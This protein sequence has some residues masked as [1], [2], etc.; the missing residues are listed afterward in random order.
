MNQA[1]RPSQA[2]VTMKEHHFL[3]MMRQLAR[4]SENRREAGAFLLGP[5]TKSGSDGTR[6]VTAVAYYCDLDEDCLTGGITFHAVGYTRLNQLCRELGSCVLA[7][8]HLHPGRY[9]LQSTTDAAHPM[10]A[11]A[12][13]LALIAPDYGAHV[14]KSRQLGAHVKTR[15]A[16]RPYAG[17]EVDHVFYVRTTPRGLLARIGGYMRSCKT[18]DKDQ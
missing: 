4:Q 9:T 10:V 2:R 18:K 1:D 17:R 5:T 13:H 11:R 15:T 12:G 3:T 16:W 6:V 7:D 8:I 14:S